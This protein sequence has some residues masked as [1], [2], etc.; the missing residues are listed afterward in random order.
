MGHE[1]DVMELCTIC[2]RSQETHRLFGHRFRAPRESSPLSY[3]GGGGWFD[4]VADIF[5]SDSSCS[6][7]SG[8]SGCSD[9]GGG[10]CGGGDGGCG[11]E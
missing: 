10:D 11:G 6:S 4:S 1:G 2:G 8:D 7:D 3:D 5:S 9:S